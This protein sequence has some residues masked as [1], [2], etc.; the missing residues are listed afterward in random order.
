MLKAVFYTDGGFILDKTLGGSGVH[1]YSYDDDIRKKVTFTGWT[2][3]DKGYISN[4]RPIDDTSKVSP[5]HYFD[6]SYYV[7]E[8]NSNMDTEMYAIEMALKAINSGEM[9]EIGNVLIRTDSQASM[10][11][12]NKMI[13]GKEVKDN[14]FYKDCLKEIK[15]FK[16]TIEMRHVK[17]HNGWLGNETADAYATMGMINKSSHEIF[18][19]G[20]GYWNKSKDRNP[21]INGRL[22]ILDSIRD[23]FD[24]YYRIINVMED[25]YAG[26]VDP[27]GMGFSIYHGEPEPLIER[28]RVLL[29]KM[30][31]DVNKKCS[32]RLG[33]LYDG[34][35]FRHIRLFGN[36]GMEARNG[37]ISIIGAGSTN[38]IVKESAERT[39][40]PEDSKI[41]ARIIEPVALIDNIANQFL[42]LEM[43]LEDMHNHSIYEYVDITDELRGG[44]KKIK[45]GLKTF[46][47]K[48]KTT[49]KDKFNTT[50]V[51]K[52]GV[53]APAINQLNRM[54][55]IFLAIIW[56][57]KRMEFCVVGIKYVKKPEDKFDISDALATRDASSIKFK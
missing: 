7:G 4:E 28:L 55:K 27:K 54:D 16:G 40:N 53:N 3:T 17:A 33:H 48:Y 43:A 20:K 11:V 21:F 30:T 10:D 46:K 14:K 5:L 38:V 9:G 2:V 23:D 25:S 19:D 35:N 31:G 56:K 41:L 15:S 37:N 22:V 34:Y 57:E 6:G 51:L 45:Q 8:S 12:M 32:I 50:V 44:E 36:K 26:R 39:G 47:Y 24:P 42:F 52:Y 49:D 29:R 1:G 18:S 13:N